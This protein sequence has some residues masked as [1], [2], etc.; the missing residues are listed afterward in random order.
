MKIK[1]QLIICIVVFTAILLTTGVSA[2]MTEQ[3]VAQVHTQEGIASNIERG[4]SNLNSIAMDYFLYQEDLQLSRW[5]SS[6]SSLSSDL[7]NLKT[8]SLQ[9]QTLANSIAADLQRLNSLF[10]DVSSYLQGASRNVSVR[11]DPAFQIRWSSMSV[12]SQALAFDASQL[13]RSLNDQSHQLN[14][15]NTVLIVS[16]L[17]V[18]GA[19][20]ATIY[21]MVFRRT[22]KSVAELQTGI[23]T[24]GSGDLDYVIEPEREDEIAELSHAFNQMTSNLKTV[25]ASKGELEKEIAERRQ[26]QEQLEESAV[27]LEEYANLMEQLA[28]ERANKLKE[29]ERLAAIGATAGMVGHDIRNPLQSI[30]GDL[31]LA[32]DGLASITQCEEKEGIKESLE[33]IEKS[34]DYVNKIVADLQDFAKPLNPHMEKTN[35]GNILNDLLFKNGV[36]DNIKPKVKIAKD[37]QTLTTDSAYLRRILGNLITNAIQAMPNGGKLTINATAKNGD[38]IITI[39]DTGVGIPE[40]AKTKLFQPLFTTK[41]KGQGFGLSV[42]KRMTEALNGTVTFESEQEKGTKFIITLPQKP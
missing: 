14:N 24:I 34:V 8:S 7:S 37:T 42:V 10:D 33:A 40:E 25:T 5:E 3:Q 39:Q 16:L 30:V 19:F 22:L 1:T 15:T 2:A 11:I 21:L 13:S 28:N 23:S 32:K 12:Q 38:I 29:A 36:P 41:S 6:L 31:Y 26:L 4:A 18:F 9:Q 20:L 35:L 27:K 17:G